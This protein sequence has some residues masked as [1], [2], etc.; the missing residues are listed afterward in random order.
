MTKAPPPQPDLDARE[1]NLRALTCQFL[2]LGAFETL[3]P[4]EQTRVDLIGALREE[5]RDLRRQQL[6][7]RTDVDI[8]RLVEAGK[9]LQALLDAQPPEASVTLQDARRRL[10]EVLGVL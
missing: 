1:R 2:R 4:A 7:G 9:Q 6:L 10:K 8:A 3:L 5:V